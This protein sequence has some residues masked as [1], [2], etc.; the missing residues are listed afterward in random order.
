MVI[1]IPSFEPDHRLVELVEEIRESASDQPIVVVNDGS[2]ATYDRRFDAV[3]YLGCKVIAYRPN[4]G[5]G[6]AL[7]AGF[8][9][10]ERTHT[11]AGVVCADGDGQH[12]VTDILRVGRALD[13]DAIVLGAR[14]FDTAVPARSR[15][16]NTV[17]RVLFRAATGDAVQDTQTGLR[18]FPA[19][20]LPWLQSVPG[21]RYEYELSVLLAAAARGVACYEIPIDTIYFEH[22]DS[23]HFR[24]VRDSMRVYVPLV[25]AIGRRFGNAL[26]GRSRAPR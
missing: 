18:G 2:D 3:R 14:R 8:A 21:E 9:H 20:M 24:A 11:G 17:T 13:S 15:L 23:S 12:R 26:G 16:G 22:N 25:K 5:K 1:L 6:H 10:I 19:S 4:R 7:K